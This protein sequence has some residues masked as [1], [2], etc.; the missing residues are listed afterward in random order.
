MISCFFFYGQGVSPQEVAGN[1][2]EELA[3]NLQY[4]SCI[5]EHL[6]DQVDCVEL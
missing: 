6:Q 1:A 4:D 3:N 5:D 2:V